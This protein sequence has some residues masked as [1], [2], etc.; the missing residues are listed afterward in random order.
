MELIWGEKRVGE[1][2]VWFRQ[3]QEIHT[4]KWWN[5]ASV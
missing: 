3:Y 4:R 5:V 2:Q 1:V